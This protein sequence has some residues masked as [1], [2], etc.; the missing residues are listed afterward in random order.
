M[1]EVAEWVAENTPFDRLYFYG[2][3]RPMLSYD[4]EKKGEFVEMR[5]GSSGWVI[6]FVR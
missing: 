2:S 4:P 6:L 3:D 5:V 1:L